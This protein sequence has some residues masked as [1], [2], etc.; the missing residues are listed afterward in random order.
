VTAFADARTLFDPARLEAVLLFERF[1]RD[2][3]LGNIRAGTENLD[4]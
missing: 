2:H 3:S 1:I 4:A